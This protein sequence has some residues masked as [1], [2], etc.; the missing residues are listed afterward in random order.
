MLQASSGKRRRGLGAVS[1]DETG[2]MKIF[3]QSL[4]YFWRTRR[5]SGCPWID[6]FFGAQT[7]LHGLEADDE[8][9]AGWAAT[10]INRPD[11]VDVLAERLHARLVVKGDSAVWAFHD[12]APVGRTTI[13]L[14]K[15]FNILSILACLGGQDQSEDARD[16][17][18][19]AEM[20]PRNGEAM[21]VG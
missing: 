18:A 2:F 1:D 8:L 10:P 20:V 21:P 11:T 19:L 12:V 13:I 7:G 9:L 5:T 17:A 15:I 3:S 16:F 4:G 6:E 14:R